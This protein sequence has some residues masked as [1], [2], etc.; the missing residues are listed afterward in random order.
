MS[1]GID[2][3]DLNRYT[4][5]PCRRRQRNSSEVSLLFHGKTSGVSGHYG[6]SRLHIMTIRYKILPAQ[7]IFSVL[8]SWRLRLDAGSCVSSMILIKLFEPT[9]D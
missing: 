5:Q 4:P 8:R 1:N 7:L 3:R 6:Y 9:P 2:N